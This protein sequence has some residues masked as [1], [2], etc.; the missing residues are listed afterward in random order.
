MAVYKIYKLIYTLQ[1]CTTTGSLPYEKQSLLNKIH[2]KTEQSLHYSLTNSEVYYTLVLQTQKFYEK[3]GGKNHRKR[4][5]W[6][7]L[8]NS[9]YN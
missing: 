5:I 7:N 3:G 4:K 8:I 2:S 1:M 9:Q 6:L